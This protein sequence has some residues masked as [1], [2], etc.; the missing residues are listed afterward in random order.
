MLFHLMESNYNA[1]AEDH[2]GKTE[3]GSTVN[4]R[5]ENLIA[6][7]LRNPSKGAGSARWNHQCKKKLPMRI[8]MKE[9]ARGW[10]LN[11]ARKDLL[12]ETH[13]FLLNG[14]SHFIYT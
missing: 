4:C 14:L 1:A 3:E 5:V 11:G 12:Y 9:S 6:S 13:F 8:Q 10:W 7:F 2:A